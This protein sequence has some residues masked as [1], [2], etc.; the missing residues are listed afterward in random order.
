MKLVINEIQ[1]KIIK[2]LSS[3]SSGVEEFI[4]LV[5]SSDGL[6]RYLGFTSLKSLKDFIRDGD[7]DDFYELKKESQEFFR[8]NK[9]K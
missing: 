4:E 1:N 3:R 8:K 2:E 5:E 9:E 6:L 7:Q